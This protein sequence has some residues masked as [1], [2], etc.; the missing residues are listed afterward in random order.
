M[1]L[2]CLKFNVCRRAG[3]G[4][5]DVDIEWMFSALGGGS[6]CMNALCDQWP[7][8][9]WLYELQKWF[10]FYIDYIFQQKQ[11]ILY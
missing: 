11:T 5:L 4:E 8:Q 1:C 3:G 10:P 7:G 2:M 6:E 9:L